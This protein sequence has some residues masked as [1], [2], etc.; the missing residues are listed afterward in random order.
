[1][2]SDASRVH[3]LVELDGVFL[4]TG[5]PLPIGAWLEPDT[6]DEAEA[7]Q[8][9]RAPGKSVW[10]TLRTTPSQATAF[11]T[12]Q[13]VAYAAFE[14]SVGDAKGVAQR[15][16]RLLEIVADP[17]DDKKLPG[18]E[19]HSLIEGIKRPAGA[20]RKPHQRF[21]AELVGAFNEIAI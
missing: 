18:W 8:R 17:R 6:G 9:G 3:R 11:M 21:L 19:G 12:R 15:H 7:L 2:L 5:Q 14:V 13:A 20:P 16:A 10:D 1:M 4:P